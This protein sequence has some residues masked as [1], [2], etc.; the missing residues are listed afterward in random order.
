[1]YSPNRNPTEPYYEH[2][3]LLRQEV[4]NKRLV[5]RPIATLS[6]LLVVIVASV[7]LASIAVGPR[8]V[9]VVVAGLLMWEGRKVPDDGTKPYDRLYWNIW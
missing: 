1:M 2:P 7:G 3:A 6:T 4:R 8:S 9:L 5:R